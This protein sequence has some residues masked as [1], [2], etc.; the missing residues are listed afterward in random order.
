MDEKA[1]L[2]QKDKIHELMLQ[3][4]YDDA[5]VICQALYEELCTNAIMSAA[6]DDYLK[7]LAQLNAVMVIE[8]Q[9]KHRIDLALQYLKATEE[10]P[11]SIFL[12]ARLYWLQSNHFQSLSVLETYF[13]INTSANTLVLSED[14]PYYLCSN[15]IKERVLNLLGQAYKYY[16]VCELACACYLK[17]S[18]IIDDFSCKVLEYSNYLFNAH[19]LCM[20]KEEYLR[21][22]LGFDTLFKHIKPY[23]HIKNSH[24]RHRKIRIGYISPDLR[25]HVVL[26]FIWGML[27]KYNREKFEIHC[28]SNS[29][30]EDEYSAHIKKHV[31]SWCNI[32]RLTPKQAAQEIYRKE[33]DVLVELAGHSQNNCL[34]VLA[35]KPAPIQ[36]CGIG[37]FATT[38]LS[39]VD[40]FLTDKYL[41]SETSQAYFTEKLLVLP[42]SHFCYVPLRDMPEI[43]GAPCKKNG[44]ITFGSLNNVTKVNDNVLQVWSVLLNKVPNSKLLLKSAQLGDNYCYE[45]FKQKLISIGVSEDCFELRGFSASYLETYYEIDIALDTFPYPGGGT[46][47]DA[48]YMGVPVVSLGDGSH[49]G[50]FGIS[51]LHNIGLDVCCAAS[52]DEYIEK[53]VAIAGDYELLDILHLGLRSIMQKSPVMNQQKYMR[54]LECCYEDVWKTYLKS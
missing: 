48:L 27:T 35:Y 52:I 39:T 18:E 46:T 43:K 22:H 3:Q 36:I 37:Y 54:D 8:T 51:L 33:I 26:L 41:V 17:S 6:R 30:I 12:M 23:E 31:G 42:H 24:R 14:S 25:Q 10:N 9:S 5:D 49:G 15:E 16:G 32:S 40:Y 53:A 38:G 47:C 1:F 11:Y 50:N 28:F 21:I 44:Y 34:S 19:Y 20:P 2:K 45:I 29:C 4:R 13:K 7:E